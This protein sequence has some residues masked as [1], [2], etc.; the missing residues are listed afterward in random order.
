M[1]N[2][3]KHQLI[4]IGAGP[5]GC[6]AAI[7]AAEAGLSVLILEAQTFPRPRPG[8]TL[9]PGIEPLFQELG[10]MQHISSSNYARP[11]G[12]FCHDADRTSFVPYREDDQPEPWRGWLIPRDEMDDCLLTRA[13][14]VGA[15]LQQCRVQIKN[16]PGIGIQVLAGNKTFQCDYLLDAT[17]HNFWLTRQLAHSINKMSGHLTGYYG[18]CGGEFTPAAT[19][20]CFYRG[21]NSWT[22]IA[23]L[24][25]F[26]Y[27][28]THLD[29][30]GQKLG[31]NWRPS[32]MQSMRP[33]GITKSRDVTWRIASAPS[34][35]NYFCLGDAA[36][37][38]DPSSS[39]GVLKAVM[40]GM[41]AAHLINNVLIKKSID[42]ETASAYY[43]VWIRKWFM[44]EY[45]HLK[46]P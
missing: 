37:V 32:V 15:R 8:E 17:G 25:P 11:T 14:Q 16:A 10:I 4:I 38:T 44:H 5:A 13:L 42:R 33:I 24:K 39:Q 18:T 19:A 28:W 29:Y 26:T 2:N 21:K 27:Q 34:G 30:S 31:K 1:V 7:R 35:K 6:A 43:D 46:K 9:H 36:F 23:E 45:K 12:F 3:V 22:W 40:S 41:M 20:P